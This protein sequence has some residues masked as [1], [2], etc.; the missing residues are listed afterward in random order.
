MLISIFNF[1]NIYQVRF[2]VS[3]FKIKLEIS[4]IFLRSCIFLQ[5]NLS[6]E[7]HSPYIQCEIMAHPLLSEEV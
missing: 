5:L 1:S 6:F 7:L 2:L 3:I 4:F